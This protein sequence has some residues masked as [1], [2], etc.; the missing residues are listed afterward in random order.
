MERNGNG[1]KIKS[2][3]NLLEEQQYPRLALSR[4]TKDGKD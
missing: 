2:I 1:K 3:Y 4:I